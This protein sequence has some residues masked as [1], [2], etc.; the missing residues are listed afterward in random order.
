MACVLGGIYLLEM[1]S[2]T[3]SEAPGVWRVLFLH[4]RGVASTQGFPYSALLVQR[5][6]PK[7]LTP[8]PDSF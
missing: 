3:V 7:A 6:F 4:P 5:P 1:G 2:K 8:S